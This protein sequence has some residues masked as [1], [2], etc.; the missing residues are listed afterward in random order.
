MT[1]DEWLATFAAAAHVDPPS[2]EEID[3]LLELAGIAAHSSERTAAPV[4]CWIAASA[5][6]TPSEA[7]TL[8]RS[9][10]ADDG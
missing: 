2:D 3:A 9:L 5:G 4:A 10:S 7:L 8:A 1:R 6:L